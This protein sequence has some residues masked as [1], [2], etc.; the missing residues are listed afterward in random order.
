MLMSSLFDYHDAYIILN[1]TISVAELAVGRS[2]DN[3]KAIFKNYVA[4]TDY[5]SEIENTQVDKAKDIDIVLPMY[6]R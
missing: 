5:I 3:K 1:E 2:K 6:K 4:F